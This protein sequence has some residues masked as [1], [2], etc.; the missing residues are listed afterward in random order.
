MFRSQCSFTIRDDRLQTACSV[1]ASLLQF[2]V[3]R[4]TFIFGF[5]KGKISSLGLYYLGLPK[6]TSIAASHNYHHLL[7][8]KA[9]SNFYL[10]P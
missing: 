10:T 3:F 8:S 5:P 7:F 9:S 2:W 6:N 1:L 4:M